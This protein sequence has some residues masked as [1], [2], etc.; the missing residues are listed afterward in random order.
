MTSYCASL[1]P[2]GL[3]PFKA[4]LRSQQIANSTFL[5]YPDAKDDLKDDDDD[6]DDEDRKAD[7]KAR[8]ILNKRQV[9]N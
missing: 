9:G 8:N 3:E 6:D 1:S 5:N 2:V 4:T 7:L